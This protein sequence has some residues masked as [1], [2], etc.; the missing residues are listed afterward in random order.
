M[1]STLLRQLTCLI[2][3]CGI[4][5]AANEPFEIKAGDRV[6]LIGDTWFEREGV[7]ASLETRLYQRWAPRAFT[8]RNLSFA[9]DR[10]DG[11]SR[12]SFDPPAAGFKRL[13]E[14]LAIAKPTVAIMSF[15][16]RR[17][18]TSSTV[19]SRTRDLT[20]PTSCKK[21]GECC[22]IHDPK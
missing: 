4:A 13:Q 7:M 18:L 1:S 8:V 10:P 9:A 15:S 21:R 2:V 11:V 22:M 20:S 14:Q 3:A 16:A 12:S 19:V 5:H 17:A 6:V